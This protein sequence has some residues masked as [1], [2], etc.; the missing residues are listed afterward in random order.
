MEGSPLMSKA[1]DF[2][3]SLPLSDLRRL[4]AFK[5]NEERIIELR[6]RRQQLLEEAAAVQGEIDSLLDE[7]TIV[8]KKRRSG[9]SMRELCIQVLRGRKRGMTAAEIRR[10][11]EKKHPLKRGPST[12]N[13]VYIALTRNSEFEKLEGN[14]FRLRDS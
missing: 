14:R 5:E 12:Y 9:P 3:E 8:K 4:V 10:V 2:L 11:I 7:V 1:M 6:D 13:Q